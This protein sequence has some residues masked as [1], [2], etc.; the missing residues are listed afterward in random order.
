MIFL[1]LHVRGDYSAETAHRLLV[2][3]MARE[4]IED[5]LDVHCVCSTIPAKLQF[6]ANLIE[7]SRVEE[8]TLSYVVSKVAVGYAQHHYFYEGGTCSSH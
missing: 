1:L 6:M 8:Y 5:V 4:L 2:A 7:L 3:K